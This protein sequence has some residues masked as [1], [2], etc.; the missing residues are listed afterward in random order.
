[1]VVR[2]EWCARLHWVCVGLQGRRVYLVEADGC[3]RHSYRDLTIAGQSVILLRVFNIIKIHGHVRYLPKSSPFECSPFRTSTSVSHRSICTSNRVRWSRCLL[4]CW[5]S[6]RMHRP[7]AFQIRSVSHTLRTFALY[8]SVLF[9]YIC[10]R[11]PFTLPTP[12][13]TRLTITDGMT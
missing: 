2:V 5:C 10:P 4:T 7:A 12:T 1:M 9:Y 3:T 6:R 13:Y 11:T 8:I